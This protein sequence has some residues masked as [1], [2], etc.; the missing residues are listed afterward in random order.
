MK[1]ASAHQKIGSHG[2]HPSPFGGS[3]LDTLSSLRENMGK[4]GQESM[5]NP[6]TSMFFLQVAD[7]MLARMYYV[8]TV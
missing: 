5:F 8:L 1:A 7:L 3:W 2:V 6:L 4:N